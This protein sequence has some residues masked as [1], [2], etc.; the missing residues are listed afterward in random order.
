MNG[1]QEGIY[2]KEHLFFFF[3]FFFLLRVCAQTSL[4]TWDSLLRTDWR[5]KLRSDPP[6]SSSHTA[7]QITEIIN[8]WIKSAHFRQNHTWRPS[9]KTKRKKKIIWLTHR[10]FPYRPTLHFRCGCFLVIDIP[11]RGTGRRAAE[12]G[13]P[14]V[15]SS[16]GAFHRSAR[17]SAPPRSRQHCADSSMNVT[18]LRVTP[19]LV[20][21]W[22]AA[23]PGL[24]LTHGVGSL[25]ACF[26]FG[27]LHDLRQKKKKK[28]K[29]SS[30]RSNVWQL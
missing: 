23:V 4:A 16:M 27:S 21:E 8:C 10:P 29:S 15:F 26:R 24:S 3:F 14:S 22:A 19:Q 2:L 6:L 13:C 20:C 12:R 1:K 17:L 28:K 30:H 5:R 25:R 9:F 7:I 11:W 18:Q